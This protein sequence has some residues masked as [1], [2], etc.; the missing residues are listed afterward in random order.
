METNKIISSLCYFS[1]LFIGG[2]FPLVVFFASDD[3]EVKKH[4]K[5]AFLSHIVPIITIP[6]AIVAAFFGINGNEAA[7]LYI[8]FP[9]VIICIIL[10]LV[11]L[12]WN[13]VQGIRVLAADKPI[14][15][16]A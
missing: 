15:H 14:D 2:I 9:T 1:V 3:P 6:F 16:V 7:M 5:R 12:I 10:T 4:A 13:I 8:L 11:V